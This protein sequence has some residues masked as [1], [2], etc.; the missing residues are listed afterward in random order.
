MADEAIL[1]RDFLKGAGA[2]GTVMAAAIASGRMAAAQ[3]APPT[4]SADAALRRADLVLKNGNVVTVDAAFTIAQAIAIAGDRIVAV[5]PDAAMAAHTAPGTLVID[6][7]GKTVIP[8]LIDGHAHMDREGL[9]HVY[10]S[11]GRVRS[12]HDI[13]DR[14][15]E[16]VRKADPGEWIVTMPIGDPPFCR[17]T[18]RRSGTARSHRCAIS[19]MRESMW[20]W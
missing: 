1:R 17:R 19:S 3:T 2:A 10:P 13:Q 18:C 14:I 4:A 15:A 12:I 6:L 20:D 5:G 8:G 11:L 16:L 7:K 9:K